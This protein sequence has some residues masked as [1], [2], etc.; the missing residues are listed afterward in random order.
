MGFNKFGRVTDPRE[1]EREKVRERVCVCV[2]ACVWQCRVTTW[3]TICSI[4]QPVGFAFHPVA[5]LIE[6]RRSKVD[7]NRNVNDRVTG[8]V[9]KLMSPR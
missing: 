6:T 9:I 5:L 3:C 1:K 8:F 4:C 2:C 7:R